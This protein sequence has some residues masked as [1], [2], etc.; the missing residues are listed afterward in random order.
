MAAVFSQTEIK[1]M[2]LGANVG[3]EINERQVETW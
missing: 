1:I 3:R 2:Q